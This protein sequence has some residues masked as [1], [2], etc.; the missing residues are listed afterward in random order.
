MTHNIFCLFSKPVFYIKWTLHTVYNLTTLAVASNRCDF[1]HEW[2]P[3]T[4][5][6]LVYWRLLW[7]AMYKTCCVLLNHTLSNKR[8]FTQ[9]IVLTFRQLYY[10]VGHVDGLGDADIDYNGNYLQLLQ[11]FR[12][13]YCIFFPR[14]FD[15]RIL[16]AKHTMDKWFYISY[17]SGWC[18]LPSLQQTQ[19]SFLS[20]GAHTSSGSPLRI[21][22]E[23]RTSFSTAPVNIH[24]LW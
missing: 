13:N 7:K 17:Q 10:S 8:L 6:C 14:R 9:T 24:F 5:Y 21:S 20:L 11:Y 16:P 1:I 22:P 12:E 15:I 18:S 23:Q 3:I 19:C 4:K 2:V